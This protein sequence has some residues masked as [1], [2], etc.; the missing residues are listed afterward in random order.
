MMRP[1]GSSSAGSA[2]VPRI[3]RSSSGSR[4][5][6]MSTTANSTASVLP[7]RASRISSRCENGQAAM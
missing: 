7:L 2:V 3:L 6:V 4:G 5:L 1:S